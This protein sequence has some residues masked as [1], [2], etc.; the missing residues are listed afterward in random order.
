MFAGGR[1]LYH[2]T[3]V[4]DTVEGFRLAGESEKA[5]GQAYLIA[6]EE[7]VTLSEF[8]ALIAEVLGVGKPWLKL[9]VWPLYGAAW[10]CEGICVPLRIQAAIYRRESIFFVKTALFFIE[11]AKRDLAIIL[12]SGCAR[13]HTHAHGIQGEG[14]CEQRLSS[15]SWFLLR[16]TRLPYEDF[17]NCVDDA[18]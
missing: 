10:L 17:N 5:V 18:D 8:A 13:D 4:A 14:L 7:Y 6:G 1:A 16:S 9:P 3:F 15:L 12:R 2:L 11:K